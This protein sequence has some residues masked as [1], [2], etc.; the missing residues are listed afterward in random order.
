VAALYA[1]C[2]SGAIPKDDYL[3]LIA[4]QGF[5]TVEIK[6]SR[7][8]EIPEEVVAEAA[9]QAQIADAKVKDLHVLSITVTGKKPL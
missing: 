6:T 9:S 8:I 4:G 2:I 7:R 3:K 5:E 1:G